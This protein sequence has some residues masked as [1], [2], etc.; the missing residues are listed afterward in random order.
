MK[1]N[2]LTNPQTTT[3]RVLA[4]VLTA[5][6]WLGSAVMT[7]MTV[8]ALRELFLWGLTLLFV[9]SNPQYSVQ[10]TSAL[11]LAH[12]CLIIIL[13]IV[14]LSSILISGDYVFNHAGERRLNRRLLTLVVVEALIVA[15]TWWI[16]WR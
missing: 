13:G 4:V 1:E 16:F 12:H 5:L 15:P 14:E 3:S 9:Q 2:T 11:T 8:F 7:I 10:A 6:L